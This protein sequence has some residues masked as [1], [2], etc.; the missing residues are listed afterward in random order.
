MEHHICCGLNHYK[1]PFS[2]FFWEKI[3]MGKSLVIF[4]LKME[5]HNIY[6]GLTGLGRGAAFYRAAQLFGCWGRILSGWLFPNIVSPKKIEQLGNLEIKGSISFI[7][8][9]KHLSIFSGATLPQSMRLQP[10]CTMVY[11]RLTLICR[12][13]DCGRHIW[14]WDVPTLADR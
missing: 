2:I 12:M 6:R 9:W 14:D 8:S 1:S 10:T 11:C 5:K 7:H 13:E 4:L 3:Q